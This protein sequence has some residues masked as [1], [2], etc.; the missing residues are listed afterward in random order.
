MICAR[1]NARKDM[2]KVL[3]S[4]KWLA[5]S[6]PGRKGGWRTYAGRAMEVEGSSCKEK[7]RTTNTD[8]W[9]NSSGLYE[10]RKR[11]ASSPWHRLRFWCPAC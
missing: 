6:V 8:G 2:C 3:A 11:R 1:D 9:R 4:E 5:G 7:N 10:V